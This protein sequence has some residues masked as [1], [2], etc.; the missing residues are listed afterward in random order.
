ME[1]AASVVGLLAVVAKVSSVLHQFI[2]GCIDAPLIA[3]TTCDEVSDFGYA[4]SKLQPY[5][6]GSS[7]IKLLGASMTDVNQL[8]VTLAACVVTFSRMEKT[9][10]RLMP[11]TGGGM[12]PLSRLRWSWAEKGISQ[13]V[14]RLQQHKLSLTLLL[15]IWIRYGSDN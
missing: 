12:D 1:V 14:Q 3:Q 6:D 2:S 5:I 10:D 8:S 7:P 13:L 11:P 4:L 9:M 15:T